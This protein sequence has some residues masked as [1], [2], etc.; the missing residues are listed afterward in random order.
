RLAVLYARGERYGD[1]ARVCQVLSEIYRELGHE[2]DAARYLEASR[3]YALRAPGG[4]P[5]PHPPAPQLRPATPARGVAAGPPPPPARFEQVAPASPEAEAAASSV[6]EF[7]FDVPDHL[8]IEPEAGA[9]PAMGLVESVATREAR[10]PAPADP[11]TDISG[12]W[13]SML[14]VEQEEGTHS[15]K[16]Q[17]MPV[18]S[19]GAPPGEVRVDPARDELTFEA[20][21]E[22]APVSAEQVAEKIEAIRHYIHQ[23]VW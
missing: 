6:Q 23:E 13:E 14:S 17:E 20:E 10:K 2:K 11:E 18:A 16:I 22:P 1:A 12:E 21:E 19:P 7:S 3:K 8:L 9:A 5:S 15:R 4:V